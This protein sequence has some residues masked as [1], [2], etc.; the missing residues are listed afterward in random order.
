MPTNTLTSLAIL[1]VQ[2]NRNN[3]Y[4]SYLE[5]FVLQILT[6]STTNVVTGENITDSLRQRF[7]LAIPKRTVEILLRRIT[8]RKILTREH[9]EFRISGSIPDPQ[10]DSKEAEAE[11][12]IRSVINGVRRFSQET[13][14]P[15][16]DEDQ[17]V[18]AICAFLSEFDVSCLR[19]YLRGTA[20]PEVSEASTTDKILVSNYVQSIHQNEPERFGSFLVLVQG[21][22]L[23]NALVCPDLENAPKSFSGLTFYLDTPLLVRRLGLEGPAK[24]NAA[25]ELTSLVKNLGGKVAAFSHSREELNNVIRGAAVYLETPG[26]RGS[27]IQEARQVGTTRSDLVILAETLHDKLSNAG[28]EI[29]STPGYTERIQIDEAA[30]EQVLEDEVGYF[31]PRAKEFDVNSVRS[32]FV[33]RDKK[34]ILSLEKSH[35]VLVTSNSAFAKAA[36]QYGQRYS[37]SHAASTVITDFTL[38]NL[39]WLKAPMGGLAVPL[40]QLMAFSYAALQPSRELLGKYLSE[41]EKLENEGVISERDHQLLRSSP[42]VSKEL[43]NL[44][45]GSDELLTEETVTEILER[46]TDEIKKEEADRSERLERDRFTIQKAFDEEADRSERLERDRLT[47]QEALDEEADR[48][49]RLERDRLTTQEALEDQIEQNNKILSSLFWQCRKSAKAWARGL[50]LALATV[51]IAIILVSSLE[52]AGLPPVLR[53]SLVFVLALLTGANLIYGLTVKGLYQWI[54]ETLQK[55]FVKRQADA[56]GVNLEDIGTN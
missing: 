17:A 2:I 15:L 35:A 6:D 20:I 33:K 22:M 29:E 47:T 34:Q 21:H 46:V 4:L 12:H 53:W 55:R 14:N 8:R 16:E 31:N 28:I 30:F 5:P 32:I 24:Q 45:L 1:R 38:A 36:W 27:I 40:T 49:E 7:G 9:N 10:L 23:A 19:S 54:E 52:F 48:S 18:E 39:A 3:D 25:T 11:R 43:M 51:L 13:V 26:G 37:P 42:M 44:T 56:L 50:S 41:I